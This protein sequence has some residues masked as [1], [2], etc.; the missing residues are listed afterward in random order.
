MGWFKKKSKKVPYIPQG[1]VGYL[2]KEIG[3]RAYDFTVIFEEIGRIGGRSKCRVI[4]VDVDRDCNKT[5]NQCLVKWGIGD[6]LTTGNIHWETDEQRAER[7]GQT[8]PVTYD[9]DEEE[10]EEEIQYT[11]TPHTFTQ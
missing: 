11:L 8:I 9:M 1:R 5:K 7:L 4:E 3:S 2:R 10:L 6:W